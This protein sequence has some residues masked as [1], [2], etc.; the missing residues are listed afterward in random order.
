MKLIISEEMKR[1]PPIPE[2]L[3]FYN[4]AYSYCEKCGLPWNFCKSKSVRVSEHTS[5]FATCT[6]C[7]ENSTLTELQE[8]YTIVYGKQE[9]SCP[10][11][12]MPHTL[13]YLLKCVE[14]EYLKK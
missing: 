8:Y 14:D 1:V 2:I 11:R 5:T 3:R 12:T 4:P 6:V 10:E 13:E 9:R 7:W